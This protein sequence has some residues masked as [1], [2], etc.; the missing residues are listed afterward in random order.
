MTLK[1]TGVVG[2]G[3]IS[4]HGGSGRALGGGGPGGP[5]SITRRPRVDRVHHRARR[6]PERAGRQRER[7]GSEQADHRR[8]GRRLG[9]RGRQCL[10]G[11]RGRAGLPRCSAR[12]RSRSAVACA[13]RAAPVQPGAHGGNGGSVE[14]VVQSVASSNGV[15]AGG[16]NGGTGAPGGNG[17][18]VRIWAQI[19]SL[20]LLQLV[21]TSGGTG[22]GTGIP[23]GIDGLQ[24]EESAPTALSIV[25]KTGALAVHDEFARRRGLPRLREPRRRARQG[26]HDDQDRQRRC[27]PRSPPASRPTTRSRRS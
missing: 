2:T 12:T 1:A 7:L 10:A 14:L 17:G 9:R 11:R 20:I 4:T 3:A 24:Q 27:C 23:N 25:A 18:R 8:L 5:V 22:G 19:P 13:P 16:G 6:E 21:D 26:D 15:L